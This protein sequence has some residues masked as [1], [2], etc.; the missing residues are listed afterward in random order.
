MSCGVAVI[1]RAGCPKHLYNVLG[2]RQIYL[3]INNKLTY[4]LESV[5]TFKSELYKSYTVK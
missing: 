5:Q 2:L 1:V 4:G 3:A